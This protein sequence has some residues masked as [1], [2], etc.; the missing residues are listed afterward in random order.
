MS[1]VPK[2]VHYYWREDGEIVVQNWVGGYKGQEHRHSP[3]DF[4]DWVKRNKIPADCLVDLDKR[5]RS[6]R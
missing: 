4:K 5:E 2:M 3:K 6:K 1:L